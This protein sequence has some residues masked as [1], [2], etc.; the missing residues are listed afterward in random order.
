[1]KKNQ[2]RQVQ[3]CSYIILNIWTEDIVVSLSCLELHSTRTVKFRIF[4]FYLTVWGIDVNHTSKFHCSSGLLLYKLTE[5]SYLFQF[6]WKDKQV[7]YKGIGKHWNSFRFDIGSLP[8]KKKAVREIII[9]KQGINWEFIQA[10]QIVLQIHCN[11]NEC[12]FVLLNQNLFPFIFPYVWRFYLL[13]QMVDWDVKGWA[14]DDTTV[15]QII[16][17][18]WI[19]NDCIQL[20]SY[21][22]QV[23][24]YISHIQGKAEWR[25]SFFQFFHL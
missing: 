4:F 16:Q 13:Y 18:E 8:K 25:I 21:E 15:L 10:T 6:Y 3:V 19:R 7:N 11:N 14:A 9:K 22:I 2:F 17:T 5:E 1:M 23:R 12:F 24:S 20:T